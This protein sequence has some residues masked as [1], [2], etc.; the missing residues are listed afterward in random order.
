MHGNLRPAYCPSLIQTSRWLRAAALSSITASPGAGTGSG[1]S[2]TAILLTAS[3][4]TAR[5]DSGR[6]Q[7]CA[8]TSCGL[9]RTFGWPAYLSSLER[10]P[11]AHAQSAP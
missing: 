2:V 5:M 4:R 7:A 9:K 3:I 10:Y 8:I 1:T 6:P 11:A